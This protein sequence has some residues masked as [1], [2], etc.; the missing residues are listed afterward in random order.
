MAAVL[1]QEISRLARKEIRSELEGL[2]GLATRH[3]AEIAALKL[4]LK[5]LKRQLAGLDRALRRAQVLSAK[6]QTGRTR[7]SAKGLVALRRRLGLSA[8][9]LGALVGVS[10]QTI[11]HWE[12]EK[13]RP[14]EEFV[15]KLAALRKMG[16]RAV[17][18]KLEELQA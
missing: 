1:K 13:S 18:A 10:A 7:Y 4:D 5:D 17:G 15:V 12:S 3:R 14:K 2:R 16:K 11:Y 8:A 9:E 6:E